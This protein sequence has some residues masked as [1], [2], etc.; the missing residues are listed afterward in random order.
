MTST[1]SYTIIPKNKNGIP[2]AKIDLG[3][4][5]AIYRAKNELDRATA[6]LARQEGLSLGQFALLEALYSRGELSVGQAQ[7]LI[8]SSSGNIALIIKNLINANLI[9]QRQDPSDK[10][11]SILSITGEGV[12]II[13][14][15]YPKNVE[16]IG[17]KF[18]TLNQKEKMELFKLLK[19]L[20]KQFK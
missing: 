19:K 18:K 1:F 15:V 6:R 10:R 5:I 3:I 7:D 8:L 9:K 17:E 14:K 20:N 11:K 16:M 4:L 12:K 13:S 2:M